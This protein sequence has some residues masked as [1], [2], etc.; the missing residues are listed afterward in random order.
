MPKLLKTP[1]G[2]LLGLLVLIGFIA[3][4][5]Y[6]AGAFAADLGGN[7]CSDLEERIAELEATTAKKGN[8]KVTLTIYGQVSEGLTYFNVD[9]GTPGSTSVHTTHVQSNG[10]KDAESFVGFKGYAK[11]SPDSYAGFVLEIGTGGYAQGIALPGLSTNEIY[12]RQSYVFLKND[13]VGALSV[14]RVNTAT[15]GVTLVTLANTN[16]AETKLS[17]RP[18]TGPPTGSVLD[19]WDGGTTDAVRYDSPVWQGF[20]FAAS[21]GQAFDVNCLGACTANSVING[22]IWDVAVHYLHDIG[23]FTVEAAAGY[24]DGISLVAPGLALNVQDIKVW[25]GSA[26]V[27]HQPTGLFLNGSY[28]DLDWSA[29]A[30]TGV[31][32][33]DVKGWQAQGG[34]E[35]RWTRLGKTTLFADYARYE[36]PIGFLGGTVNPTMWG[37]GVVQSIEPAAM[38]LFA[39]FHRF[40]GDG[41]LTGSLDEG[42]VGA[43]IKF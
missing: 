38:D 16:V 24:R 8:R 25:S 7:C 5:G 43:R 3:F 27:K 6:K 35:E 42:L 23:E 37:F 9:P 39:T 28:G 18:L 29:F 21:W 26:A 2:I 12:T 22:D 15:Y 1:L 19:L 13:K 36:V 41:K 10:N 33:P 4:A 40:E 34:V 17:L 14:G 31:S 20:S 30:P 11:I 32:A